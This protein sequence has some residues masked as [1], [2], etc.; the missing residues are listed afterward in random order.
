MAPDNFRQGTVDMARCRELGLISVI[1][2]SC[3]RN[4]IAAAGKRSSG[5]TFGRED[6]MIVRS[7]LG[8][9]SEELMTIVAVMDSNLGA[10]GGMYSSRPKTDIFA[11][12]AVAAAMTG[13]P[14]PS[15]RHDADNHQVPGTPILMPAGDTAAEEG[16]LFIK[17][18]ENRPWLNAAMSWFWWCGEWVWW[19]GLFVLDI[20]IVVGMA[21]F[22]ESIGRKRGGSKI[23]PKKIA[24]NAIAVKA[25]GGPAVPGAPIPTPSLTP[26]R[27]SSQRL[28]MLSQE[29]FL[30][31]WLA[32]HWVKLSVGAGLA[33]AGR[34]P[35]FLLSNDSILCH[36]FVNLAV[37]LRC[38]S[39]VMLFI[40]D[41]VALPKLEKGH[42]NASVPG[43]TA[44]PQPL[45][46]PLQVQTPTS[47]VDFTR[48][49][50]A[51]PPPP[52]TPPSGSPR[53]SNSTNQ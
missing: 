37:M 24:A 33:I 47:P 46:P 45:P 34:L 12:P 31:A 10:D 18:P 38:M 36:M 42:A 28:S 4:A 44:P 43:P 25:A 3:L 1:A 53:N 6:L 19:I 39:F 48:R 30:A 23:M 51:A 52:S 27:D 14:V 11:E 7:S 21:F 49:R 16:G 22:L 41:D 35:P 40:K 9:I 8:R 5:V 17:A 15:V 50:A 29:E 20:L 32:E 13:R 26:D 2:L